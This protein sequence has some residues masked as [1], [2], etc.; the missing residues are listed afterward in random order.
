MRLRVR[1]AH[2]ARSFRAVSDNRDLRRLA[3]AFLFWG[4][5]RW[6]NRIAIYIFAFERGG[7]AETGLV[8]LIMLVPA[9]I[10]APLASVL[11]D[12]MRRDRALVL[13]F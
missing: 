11:G 2:I 10:V 3:V 1:L 4:L 12:E 9:A 5:A 8:A 7:A 6:A 13:R